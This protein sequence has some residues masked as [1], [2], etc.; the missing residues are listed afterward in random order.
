[1]QGIWQMVIISQLPNLSATDKTIDTEQSDEK[2]ESRDSTGT[3][4][5]IY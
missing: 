5:Q 1:M 3:K 4:I 2:L